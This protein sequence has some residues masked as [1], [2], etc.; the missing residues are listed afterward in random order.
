MNGQGYADDVDRLGKLAV[1]LR[2]LEAADASARYAGNGN[3]S[4]G[5]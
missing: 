5:C 1:I 2:D 4:A 3:F